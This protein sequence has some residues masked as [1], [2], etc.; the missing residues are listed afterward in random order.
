MPLHTQ[1]TKV[2]PEKVGALVEGLAEVRASKYSDHLAQEAQA[3]AQATQTL[4][5]PKF[6]IH[7]SGMTSKTAANI[8]RKHLALD[9]KPVL[10]L[11]S[12]VTTSI[13]D[14]GAQ[15]C[16]ENLT[17][18]LADGDEYPALIQL[19]QRCVSIISNLWN[20]PADERGI[21]TA[22]TGSSEAIQLGGLAML[23]RWKERQQKHNRPTDKPNIIMASCAQ[24][25][26]EKFARYWDVENRLLPIYAKHQFG[27]S[28]EDLLKNVDENTIGVFVILGSTFTGHYEDVAG[29][30]RA[31][32]AYQERTG[33]DVPIHVDAASG[34]FVAPF[35]TPELEWDFRLTRVKSIN[36]SGHKFGGTPAGCGWVI[37]RDTKYL[38]ESLLFVLDYLGGSETTFTLNFSRPGYP[39]IYQYYNFVKLGREG[40]RRLSDSAL[41]NA[42]LLSIYLEKS[43]YF[44][45]LSDIH[46]PKG[47]YFV[48]K[49]E[50]EGVSMQHHTS[51]YNPGLP[52]VSF[53]L[54]DSFKKD[55]G[56]I[57]QEAISYMLR[58]SGYIIPNYNLPENENKNECLRVVVNPYL[59]L[60]LLDQLMQDIISNTNKLMAIGRD[61]RISDKSVLFNALAAM[62]Q[63]DSQEK[64]HQ[65]KWNVRFSR[66]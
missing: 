25:A 18:N 12:F 53:K 3:E 52:V 2:D 31:L 64:E 32:D 39:I 34:G 54:S 51:Y 63:P 58:H 9:G 46:R 10:N 22:T 20:V 61:N 55:Y 62:S 35:S 23:R 56:Y 6:A 38:P 47:R 11:A 65:D 37:W 19:Q 33:I 8:V 21:G 40:Y 1:I 7:D 16:R 17:K 60:D 28:I 15:L 57:P 44:D 24:V 48:D 29:V 66:C 45:V 26:L 59:S 43:G 50:F 41:E 5:A 30:S 36:S 27:F 42:R 14:E 49:P 13:D 4:P